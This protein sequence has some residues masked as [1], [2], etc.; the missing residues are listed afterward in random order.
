MLGYYS[1]NNPHLFHT[2]LSF[3]SM[4]YQG[5]CVNKNQR[6]YYSEDENESKEN[7]YKPRTENFIV[8]DKCVHITSDRYK[9]PR[10]IRIYPETKS[11]FLTIR[12]KS[13]FEYLWLITLL[14]F[15]HNCIIFNNIRSYFTLKWDRRN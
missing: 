15:C 2:D 1:Y 6:Y 10:Y 4:D 12:Y 11:K 7:K 13:F 9:G 5:E 3:I 8:S 14:W